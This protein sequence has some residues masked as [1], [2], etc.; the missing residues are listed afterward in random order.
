MTKDA[1]EY[2]LLNAAIL[3]DELYT[4]ETPA[5]EWLKLCTTAG[6]DGFPA[7]SLGEPQSLAPLTELE[8]SDNCAVFAAH[9]FSGVLLLI[10]S[11]TAVFFCGVRCSFT[12]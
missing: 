7:G 6:K 8:V 1:P 5:E 9:L 2:F 3:P 4:V 10:H 12:P 11:L